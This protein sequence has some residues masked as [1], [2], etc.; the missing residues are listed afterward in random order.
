MIDNNGRAL[1][2]GFSLLT[3]AS[4]QSNTSLPTGLGGTIRWMS[5]ELLLPEA[6]A[7]KDSRPTKG[8]DCYALGMVIYEVLSGRLPFSR[9]NETAV[10]FKVLQG[11]C[12]RRPR[13]TEGTWFTTNLWEML[14]RCW[15]PPPDERP[16][17]DAVLQCLQDAA[18]PSRPFDIIEDVVTDVEDQSDAMSAHSSK[19]SMLGLGPQA[20]PNL[21]SWYDR[22]I[23]LASRG[24]IPGPTP[25]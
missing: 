17:L 12:P 16:G 15:K 21:P 3:M 23:D 22:S 7:M 2:A 4:N 1:L 20:H 19:F 8:S 11:E 10:I 9:C 5:P 18:R 13:G 24:S 14:G 25:R 6:F